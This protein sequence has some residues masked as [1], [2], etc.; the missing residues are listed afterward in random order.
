MKQPRL[1]DIDGTVYDPD[2]GLPVARKT[3]DQLA[4]FKRDFES[5]SNAITKKRI[6][7][8]GTT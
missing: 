6:K 1:R 3:Q 5:L 2:T 4:R 7:D 8:D